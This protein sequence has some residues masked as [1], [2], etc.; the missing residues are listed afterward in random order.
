M[1]NKAPKIKQLR[2]LDAA[3]ISHRSAELQKEMFDLRRGLTTKEQSNTARIRTARREY[4]RLQTILN[5]KN[6]A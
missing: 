2:E 1:P 5:E 6:R 3:E 4:A